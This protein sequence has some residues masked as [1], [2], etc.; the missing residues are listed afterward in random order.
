MSQALKG[1]KRRPLSLYLL[2]GSAPVIWIEEIPAL[3]VG[4]LLQIECGPRSQ[5][6]T[7]QC[8]DLLSNPRWREELCDLALHCSKL[9][10]HRQK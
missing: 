3:A 1:D 7:R 6:N 4:I 2:P 8:T 10:A 9:G 5:C